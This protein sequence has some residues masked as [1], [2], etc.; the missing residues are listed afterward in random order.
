MLEKEDLEKIKMGDDGSVSIL[1]GIN[2]RVQIM[3][4][5]YFDAVITKKDDKFYYIQQTCCK[6]GWRVTEIPYKHITLEFLEEMEEKSVE[7][8]FKSEGKAAQNHIETLLKGSVKQKIF[9]LIN[10]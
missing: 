1:E 10:S 9:I 7:S 5:L 8:F 6:D 4:C 3:Y 2:P